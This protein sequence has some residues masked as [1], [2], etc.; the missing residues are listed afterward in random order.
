M[1]RKFLKRAYRAYCGMCG[2]ETDHSGL[3]CDECGR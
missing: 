2:K 3:Y 1:I